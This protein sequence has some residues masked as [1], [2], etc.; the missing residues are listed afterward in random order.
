[1]KKILHLL[2]D[3][4]VGIVLVL[5]L[6]LVLAE[7]KRE[8]LKSTDSYYDKRVLLQRVLLQCVAH[9]CCDGWLAYNVSPRMIPKPPI[10]V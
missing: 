9:P 6:V 5:V 10:S 1:M 4:L 2:P 3:V 8:Y 7:L